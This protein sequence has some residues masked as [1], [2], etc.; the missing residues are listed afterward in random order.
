MCQFKIKLY[1]GSHYPQLQRKSVIG[2]SLGYNL[3]VKNGKFLSPKNTSVVEGLGPCLQF[4]LWS[5][6][7][8]FNSHSAPELDHVSDVKKRIVECALALKDDV[9]NKTQEVVAFITGGMKYNPKLPITAKCN[10]FINETYD[11]LQDAGINT[12]IIAGQKGD[13]LN[14]R[15]NTYARDNSI[16]CLG[17]PI[18]DIPKF[19][20][21]M[22][23]DEC[24]EILED[25]FDYVELSP[26]VEIEVI[27]ELPAKTEHLLK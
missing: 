20:K 17:G 24:T 18:K 10:E 3:T 6:H 26:D 21:G 11:A 1:R 22:D 25:Y 2:D 9:K 15:I 8:I 13:G 12:V 23:I 4:F 16:T 5:P 7:K 27:D 19:K 14:S